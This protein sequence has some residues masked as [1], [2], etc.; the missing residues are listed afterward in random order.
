MLAD[1]TSLMWLV[2]PTLT[3]AEMAST[4]KLLFVLTSWYTPRCLP[5][6]VTWPSG[7]GHSAANW[8]GCCAAATSAGRMHA[9]DSYG[10]IRYL[11]DI[12]KE[13]TT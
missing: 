8:R 11:Y 1:K 13:K 4:A 9:I 12:Y 6:W 2:H 3:Q 5:A 7:A 10:F